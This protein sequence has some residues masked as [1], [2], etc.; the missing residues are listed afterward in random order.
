MRGVLVAALAAV[1]LLWGALASAQGIGDAAARESQKRK[2]EPST[3]SKVYTK[4]DLP[5]SVAAPSPTSGLPASADDGTS[6]EESEG[7]EGGEDAA[8][9][10]EEA[11]A[12]AA[13]AWRRQLDQARQEEVVYRDVIDKLQLELNDMSGGV[14]N[15][16]RAAR[17]EFLEENK[18]LLADTQQ[19]ISTL[20]AEGQSKGYR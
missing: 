10:A 9:A 2:A 18:R 12:E 14:Y 13:A 20:E 7:G 4:S 3:S 5:P 15:P 11:E 8:A 19:K 6:E 1:G 16:G 17:V